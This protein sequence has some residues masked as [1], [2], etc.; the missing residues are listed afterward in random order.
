VRSDPV[1][2]FLLIVEL[3]VIV[4]LAERPGLPVEGVYGGN[5][6]GTGATSP[7]GVAGRSWWMVLRKGVAFVMR[8]QVEV[9]LSPTT[10]RG[11]RGEIRIGRSGWRGRSGIGIDTRLVRID[12]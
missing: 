2:I 3:F 8:A 9:F 12:R 5:R 4:F 7:C 11:W 6:G 10:T 1:V